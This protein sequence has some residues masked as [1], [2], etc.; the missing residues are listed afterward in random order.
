LYTALVAIA[1][2]PE[3]MI[4]PLRG[5]QGQGPY[6][7]IR[8][9]RAMFNALFGYDPSTPQDEVLGTVPQALF[10]MN[11]P[12][13]DRLTR[14]AGRTRLAEILRVAPSDRE[15]IRDV[16]LLVLSREPTQNEAAI[17]NEY[18]RETGERE[19]AFEDLMWSLLNS[20]EFVTKR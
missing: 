11:S 5:G 6:G 3:T 12:H 10:L 17:C 13:I 15:A 2:V 20:S 19:A 7:R 8:S 1:G 18:I 16:Y 14:A 9:P 4:N